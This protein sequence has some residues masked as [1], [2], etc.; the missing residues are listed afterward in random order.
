MLAGG[1]SC[2]RLSIRLIPSS[3]ALYL[4]VEQPQVTFAAMGS[5]YAASSAAAQKVLSL[6][7]VNSGFTYQ[8]G[9]SLQDHIYGEA[10]VMF[11][12][13]LIV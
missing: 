10:S 7:N 1:Y 8:Q 4:I 6:V 11:R 12:T 5:H 2:K 3:Y 9:L 13:Q